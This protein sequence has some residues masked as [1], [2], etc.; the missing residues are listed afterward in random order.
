MDIIQ[1]RLEREYGL[2]LIFTAPTVVYKVHMKDGTKVDIE[3]PSKLPDPTTIET[4]EEPYVA[5][6]IHTPEEFIGG[7]LKILQENVEFKRIWNTPRA[8]V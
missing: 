8:I 2:E 7:I 4:I 6:T 5:V 1:E 3:N